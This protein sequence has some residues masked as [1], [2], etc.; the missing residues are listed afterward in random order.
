MTGEDATPA[1]FSE[2]ELESEFDGESMETLLRCRGFAK[3]DTANCISANCARARE[4]SCLLL[5][6]EESGGDAELG[7]LD[8]SE[9]SR[10]GGSASSNDGLEV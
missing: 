10:K 7:W 4:G 8:C 6:R 5:L 9:L 1:G 2:S 3:A